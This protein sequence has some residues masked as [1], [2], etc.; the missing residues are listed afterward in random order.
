MKQRKDLVEHIVA[1]NFMTPGQA[2]DAIT[3]VLEGIEA[4]TL[5]DSLMLKGFGTFSM[6]FR[7][8]SI[9]KNPQTGEPRHVPSSLRI[10]L[11]GSPLVSKG[12]EF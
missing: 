1:R 6:R 5:N 7:K 11:K 4:I 3:A 9:T 8:A 10:G 2:A 12:D